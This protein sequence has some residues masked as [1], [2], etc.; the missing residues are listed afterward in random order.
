MSDRHRFERIYADHYDAVLRYCLRRSNREDA[1]D[2]TAETF[3]VAW[4]RRADMPTGRELPWLYGVARRVMANDRR[5]MAR[6]SVALARLGPDPADPIGQP[7]LQLVAHQDSGEVIAALGQLRSDDQELIRLAGWE[8]LT[9]DEL[10]MAFGTSPNAVT[11]RLNR[12]LD[13]LAHEL[14]VMERAHSRFFRRRR[15]AQ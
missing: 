10:A 13:R 2:A 7:E 3:T 11:K 8:E 6:K 1:L 14:G 5:S 9:R 4:R 12:A 15:V